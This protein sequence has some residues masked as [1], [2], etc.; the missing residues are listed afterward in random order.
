MIHDYYL[1]AL[2]Q[3]VVE[4]SGS[5]AVDLAWSLL[6]PHCSTRVGVTIGL[7]GKRRDAAGHTRM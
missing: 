4:A 1:R 2:V 7:K 5:A 6:R 3:L